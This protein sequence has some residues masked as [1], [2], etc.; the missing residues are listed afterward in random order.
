MSGRD[1]V[2]VAATGSGK[3]LAFLLPA[4]VHI[5]A[6]VK[7][8]YPEYSRANFY[9]WSLFLPRQFLPLRG[10]PRNLSEA[11]GITTSQNR[12]VVPR[13]ARI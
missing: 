2:A 8:P 11:E 3:T 5:N 7:S 10:R 6:Q 1:L 9:P 13:Q 4:M 12:L